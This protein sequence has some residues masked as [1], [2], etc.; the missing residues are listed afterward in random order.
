[1]DHPIYQKS[2]PF[3]VYA[4]HDFAAE[5]PDEICFKN[6]SPIC[7]VER[8][9]L[10]TDG[11]WKGIAGDNP[12]ELGLFPHSF[13]TA[14]QE[15]IIPKDISN[16]K[17]KLAN[18]LLSHTTAFLN[19]SSY[20]DPNK[21]PE[22]ISLVSNNDLNQNNS[23]TPI[24]TQ[25]SSIQ[26]SEMTPVT[27]SIKETSNKPTNVP[28]DSFY[29]PTPNS[30]SVSSSHNQLSDIIYEDPNFNNTTKPFSNSQRFSQDQIPP[31]IEELTEPPTVPTS[32]VIS[33]KEMFPEI[34]FNNG[35][36]KI[37]SNANY[38]ESKVDSND[39]ESKVDSKPNLRLSI[40]DTKISNEPLNSPKSDTTVVTPQAISFNSSTYNVNS[41]IV[42]SPDK[43]KSSVNEIDNIDKIDKIEKDF[44]IIDDIPME[45]SKNIS[46]DGFKPS[47]EIDDTMQNQSEDLDNED[48]KKNSLLNRRVTITKANNKQFNLQSDIN[49]PEPNENTIVLSSD[50]MYFLLNG[51]MTQYFTDWDADTVSN[52]VRSQPDL[53][54][55][56]GKI[57]GYSGAEL[58]TFSPEDFHDTCYIENMSDCHT[59]AKAIDA[60]IELCQLS[61]EESVTESKLKEDI[62]M[63][64]NEKNI[65]KDK[66]V[67]Y[68]NPTLP[69]RNS[70]G[71]PDNINTFSS[72]RKMSYKAKNSI[73]TSYEQSPNTFVSIFKK[74]SNPSSPVENQKDNVKSNKIH[75]LSMINSGNNNIKNISL[76][77]K[78]QNGSGRMSVQDEYNRLLD[79]QYEGWL[80]V[81]GAGG[82]DV[83]STNSKL[84]SKLFGNILGN[85]NAVN[86]N[87][88][89]S[90]HLGMVETGWHKR[91]CTL[92]SDKFY[93]FSDKYVPGKSAPILIAAVPLN[94]NQY[95][96]TGLFDNFMSSQTKKTNPNEIQKLFESCKSS[97]NTVVDSKR[98]V[99]KNDHKPPTEF[100]FTLLHKPFSNLKRKNVKKVVVTTSEIN[101]ENKADDED[102][103]AEFDIYSHYAEDVDKFNED[104]KENIDNTKKHLSSII[105]VEEKTRPLDEYDVQFEMTRSYQRMY[106]FAA[107]DQLSAVTWVN[108]L[109]R[110]AQQPQSIVPEFPGDETNT[111]IVGPYVVNSSSVVYNTIPL[112]TS[113]NSSRKG[114][115]LIPI[116]DLLNNESVA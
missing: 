100:C 53:L 94:E 46:I 2:I 87:S 11:W 99:W 3:I 31:S 30:L 76:N 37:D 69:S 36:P 91:W 105:T 40:I 66:G 107:L 97:I 72:K 108:K 112:R 106:S 12:N 96:V 80:W 77:K 70:S 61:V 89:A 39:I 22:T 114:L 35:E 67:A 23:I 50:E 88:N 6:F 38:I 4:R 59:V 73:N 51:N 71:F 75:S 101:S 110:V 54:K 81:K 1:M 65:S 111:R 83:G 95:T 63:V 52:W 68:I 64:E 98:K 62:D 34:E 10:Y 60:A 109:V 79:T 19:S 27:T 78:S 41:F 13:T 42:G 28:F 33:S 8:D 74:N 26:T 45:F 9:E 7:V 18:K 56:D 25:L 55:F 5:E 44:E 17:I 14:F 49:S 92:G 115:E 113:K 57:T 29:I 58:S 20:K 24:N 15:S 116:R 86:S 32:P 16:D 85:S 48:I 104:R 90:P 102:Y 21:S 47:R 82:K 84:S 93:I 103:D 43:N